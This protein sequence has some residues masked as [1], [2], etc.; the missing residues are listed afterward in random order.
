M[1]KFRDLT[2]EEIEVRVSRVT[3][4]GVELLLYKDSRCDMRI[5][6]ETVGPENWQNEFYECKGTLFCKV[7][8]LVPRGE[9][10]REWVWKDN[11][12]AP[13]N[14]EAQK[15][16]ASDAFKRACFTWG[17]GRELYTSPRIFVYADKCDKI[18]QGKNGKMQCYDRFHVEKVRIEDGQITGLS[19]W[20]DTTGHRCFVWQ[21]GE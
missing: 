21:K 4:A 19:I 12:G 16:E 2:A 15:G 7:G 11:A 5:L 14:M 6:D 13:S 17:I 9:Q 10:F 20:N 3:N 1:K 18:Q 8:I